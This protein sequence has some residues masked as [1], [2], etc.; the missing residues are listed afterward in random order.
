M[1]ADSEEKRTLLQNYPQTLIVV[2]CF[3]KW[4]GPCKMIAKDVEKLEKDYKNQIIVRKLDVD[5]NEEFVK[6]FNITGMPTFLF[7]K[8]N[9]ALKKVVGADMEAVHNTIQQLM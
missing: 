8:N 6:Y 9:T 4:C 3:A 2:D 1:L 5:E 7:L